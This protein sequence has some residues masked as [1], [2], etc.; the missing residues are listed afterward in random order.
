MKTSN[1]KNNSQ[2]RFAKIK[3]EFSRNKI[4]NKNMENAFLCITATSSNSILS[5][6]NDQGQVIK[7]LSCGM[8]FKNNKKSTPFAFQNTLGKMVE[9]IKDMGVSSIILKIHTTGTTIIRDYILEV[10]GSNLTIKKIVDT[11]SKPHNGP[12]PKKRRKM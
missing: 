10:V 11:T 9:I 4:K 3:K 7:Q 6:T 5:L 1:S 12:R 2:N 8:L